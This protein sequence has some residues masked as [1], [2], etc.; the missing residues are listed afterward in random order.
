MI[1]VKTVL[2]HGGSCPF[3]LEG[4]TDWDEK[5]YVRYR[6]G[7]LRVEVNEKTVFS[8]CI[9]ENETD[10]SLLEGIKAF[11]WDHKGDPELIQKRLESYQMMR[12]LL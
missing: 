9:G 1:N 5:V 4:L 11:D 7:W 6:G 12:V 8:K 10:E 3:Q 2:N